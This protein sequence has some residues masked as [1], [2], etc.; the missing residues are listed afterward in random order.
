[1]F[2]SIH[3]VVMMVTGERYIVALADADFGNYI[4]DGMMTAE[5]RICSSFVCHCGSGHSWVF[6]SREHF[7][8]L[9]NIVPWHHHRVQ[10]CQRLRMEGSRKEP[11]SQGLFPPARSRTS[12]TS[13]A[14]RGQAEPSAD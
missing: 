13:L 8:H 10:K 1:M 9:G 11:V 6:L 7:V 5:R 2:T 14:G 12:G 4:T 3:I